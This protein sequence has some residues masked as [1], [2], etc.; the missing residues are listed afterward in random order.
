ME[1]HPLTHSEIN[2]TLAK[3]SKNPSAA[4]HFSAIRYVTEL[5]AKNDFPTHHANQYESITKSNAN[6]FWIRELHKKLMLPFA[7]YGEAML[8]PEY[9]KRS[10]CGPYRLNNRTINIEMPKPLEINKFMHVWFRRIAEFHNQIR[11]RLAR[12]DHQ[13]LMNVEQMTRTIHLQLQCI[14]PWTDGTGRSARLVE[15]LFR[16]RWGL[17]WKTIPAKD[18]IQYINEIVEYE[19]GPNWKTFTTEAKSN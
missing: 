19:N 10:D 2:S 9:I 5:A 3:Q 17:P 6:L 1:G 13:T 12:P 4:G 18:K 7:E 16:L 11:P 14:H 8:N 15:N